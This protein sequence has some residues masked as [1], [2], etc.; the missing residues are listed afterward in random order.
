MHKDRRPKSRRPAEELAT[1]VNVSISPEILRR[2]DTLMHRRGIS[3]FSHLIATL[4]RE[5]FDRRIDMPG[6]QQKDL[7]QLKAEFEAL[8]LLPSAPPQPQ[9]P[10]PPRPKQAIR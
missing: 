5:E 8:K 10:P 6:A 3:K 9:K 1:R 2:S 7:E 4:I